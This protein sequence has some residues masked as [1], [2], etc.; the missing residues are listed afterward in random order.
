MIASD[1]HK[2][3]KY[4]PPVPAPE[5]GRGAGGA[6]CGSIH[7]KNYVVELNCQLFMYRRH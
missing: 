4:I 5:L 1:W 2:Y 7:E 6:I 3:G